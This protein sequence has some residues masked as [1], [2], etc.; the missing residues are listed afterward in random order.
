[1]NTEEQKEQNKQKAFEQL[2]AQSSDE[3]IIGSLEELRES[4]ENF[5]V[6]MLTQL[7]FSERSENL[8]QS[9]ANFLVD[10]K[11]QSSANDIVRVIKENYNSPY[12]KDAVTIC[13][14]SRL[15]FNEFIDLFLDMFI[16]KDFETS[17]EA[18]SVI[19]NALET[20]PKEKISTIYSRIEGE[21][22][23]LTSTKK[24]LA[25]QALIAM[26]GYK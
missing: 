2:I 10:L 8:K 15:S 21:L 7:I 25:H 26:E 9:V 24:E 13:W 3:V 17:F 23:N 20:L 16:E 4:G 12:I 1:M 11:N 18:L 22:Q 19:E 14:Q 6:P 5:M